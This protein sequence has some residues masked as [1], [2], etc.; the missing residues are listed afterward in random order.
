MTYRQW[1]MNLWPAAVVVEFSIRTA[2]TIFVVEF[3]VVAYVERET[4]SLLNTLA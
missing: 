3:G 4:T 1:F 2:R